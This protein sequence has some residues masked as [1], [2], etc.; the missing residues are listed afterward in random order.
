MSGSIEGLGDNLIAAAFILFVLLFVATESGYRIARLR[1]ARAAVDEKTISNAA[2]LTAGML[3][4]VAFM[5]GLSINF[6][7]S[8][9]ESRRQEVVHEANAIGTAWLRAR[10]VGGEEGDAAARLIVDY[11]QVRLDYTIAGAEGPL[12]AL[13][14]RTNALQ[15]QIWNA[16]TTVA[17]RSPTPISAG[18]VASLND[19]FDASL[20][21][22]FAFESR[23]PRSL[24]W[25]LLAGSTLALG[26]IGYQF[27]LAGHRQLI[28]TSLLLL[29]WVGAMVL[30]V[31][32]NRPRVGMLRVDAGPLEWTL[33]GF[34]APKP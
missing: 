10:L 34:G 25:M 30:I 16:A 32:F 7:Q 3:G 26:A 14:A 15:T 2:T 31:D 27:G 6:A 13:L 8:R 4:L 5:L 19:M 11:T 1:T 12:T 17:R 18:F 29:M 21:Q 20:S 23:G 24:F 28:M 33:Q 9:Y 22:R